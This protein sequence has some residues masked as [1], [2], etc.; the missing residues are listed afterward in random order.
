MGCAEELGEGV[1]GVDK[2]KVSSISDGVRER[3]V[4][5]G[6]LREAFPRVFREGDI[7]WLVEGD[8]RLSKQAERAKVVI[9]LPA[10]R[11]TVTQ[12]QRH[13]LHGRRNMIG[14]SIV[15]SCLQDNGWVDCSSDRGHLEQNSL[16]DGGR[17]P[18]ATRLHPLF[19]HRK[20]PNACR[21]C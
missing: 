10:A 12:R 14:L 7:C 13:W 9:C 5:Y 8:E 3:R 18:L 15:H 4:G 6:E 11:R 1:S 20:R 2:R 17:L 16:R 21:E 19:V